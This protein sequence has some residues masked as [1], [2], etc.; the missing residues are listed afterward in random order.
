MDFDDPKA[1]EILQR[2]E[3]LKA[4][5][6]P[7]ESNWQEIVELVRPGT[8]D[9]HKG[10]S[11]S[12]TRTENIFDG[13]APQALE[14]LANGLH[15]HLTSAA[16]RWFA[17]EVE[18]MN[19]L[20]N[21]PEALL[22]LEDVADILYDEYSNPVTNFN[23][24]LNEA[25]MDLGA[26]GL[27]VV[28]QEWS[29]KT[30]HLSF[31]AFPLAD[32]WL[33]ENSEG[34]VDTL[35]REC[36]MTKR[37]IVQMFGEAMLP[38]KV[39]LDQSPNKKWSVLHAVYPRRERE[40]AK[41]TPANM[42]F[43]SCWVLK[44]PG[45]TLK[46]SGYNSFPY[47]VPRWTKL[48][49]EV[50]GRGP[51]VKCLPDIRMLNRMEYTIIKAAQKIV[52]PPLQAP[53]DGFILPIKTAPAA[54]I[55]REPGTEP[56]EALET[57]GNIP[58]GL[59]M[60]EQKREFIR[61]CFYADW[62]RLRDKK[63]EQT[64][65]EIQEM[66]DEQLRMMEPMFG[67]LQS[68]KLGPTIARSYELLKEH[69]KLPP[70]PASLEGRRLKVGYTSPAARAQRGRKAIGIRRYFETVVP[71]AN[72]KPEVMDAINFDD[73]MQELALVQGVSRKAVNSPAQIAAIRQ[74]RAR[75]QQMAMIAENLEPASKAVKQIAEAQA[76]GSPA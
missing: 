47:H 45:R 29:D 5:R 9:F 10:F 28:N 62:L 51:A 60:S 71:F 73:A 6:Y 30:E 31:R 19:S 40:P 50:Y 48:A 8:S 4:E 24:S 65:Y 25:Y 58:I 20:E 1:K 41:Y 22:W 53:N 15:S 17:C 37:Q 44:D 11:P 3:Q 74:E 52:D 2:H 34:K 54:I 32:C 43:A 72:V 64:A 27:S 69:G 46:E 23:A 56:L 13:T 18:E 14:E 63:A 26:F 35:Y 61:K 7:Y 49:Q 39:R 33:D 42:P 66:V 68:E 21:D 76:I 67:R 57:K 38:D 59:E 12:Q 55:F 70:P 75:Q 36:Q 16:E